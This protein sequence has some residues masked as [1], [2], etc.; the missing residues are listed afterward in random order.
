ME[1]NQLIEDI[2]DIAFPITAIPSFSQGIKPAENSSAMKKIIRGSIQGAFQKKTPSDYDIKYDRV[3]LPC[4]K[5]DEVQLVI[6]LIES[7]QPSDAIE[8]A[9]ASQFAISYIQGLKSS[10]DYSQKMMELFGFGHQVLETLQKY[11]SKG[12]QQIQVNYNHNQGQINNIKVIESENKEK[13]IEMNN[14]Y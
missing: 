10:I 12:A 1:E 8:A 9:L 4:V 11:R 13:P 5:E 6:H 2:E 7:L 3:N 14:G